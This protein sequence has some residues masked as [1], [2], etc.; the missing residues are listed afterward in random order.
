MFM[1]YRHSIVL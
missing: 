1:T